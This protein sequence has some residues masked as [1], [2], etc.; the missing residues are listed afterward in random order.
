MT[1]QTCEKAMIALSAGIAEAIGD[2][3]SFAI[4]N[5]LI[6]TADGPGIDPATSEM[7]WNLIEVMTPPRLTPRAMLNK[8]QFA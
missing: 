4:V 1:D 2:E 6:G 8:Q 7:I 3:A 5:Y